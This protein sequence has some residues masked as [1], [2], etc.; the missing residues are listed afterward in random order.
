MNEILLSVVQ[1]SAKLTH[2]SCDEQTLYRALSW[3]AI[4]LAIYIY[5]YTDTNHR[6]LFLRVKSLNEFSSL[7]Q[8]Q[9][10]KKVFKGFTPV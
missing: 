4:L 2:F 10:V 3:S 9:Y 6:S 7:E 8:Y 5:I 1:R